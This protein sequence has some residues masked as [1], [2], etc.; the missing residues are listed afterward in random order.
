MMVFLYYLRHPA[1]A[2]SNNYSPVTDCRIFLPSTSAGLAAAPGL[3]SKQVVQDT[4]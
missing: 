1:A 3:L 4:Q 2:F